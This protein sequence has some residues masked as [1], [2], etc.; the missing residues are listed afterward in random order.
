MEIRHLSRPSREFVGV[1][2]AVLLA[3]I[4]AYR[5]AVRLVAGPAPDGPRSAAFLGRVAASIN[6]L[7]PRQLDAETEI[8][9]VSALDGVFIYHYRFINVAVADMPRGV[10]ARLRPTVMRS[11]CANEATL[12]NFI[13]KDITLRYHYSDKSGHALAS[14]DVTRADCGV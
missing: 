14:F 3:G 1:I 13:K 5:L 2:L 8:T 12:N 6:P 4:P 10:L 7:F 11:S 9:R